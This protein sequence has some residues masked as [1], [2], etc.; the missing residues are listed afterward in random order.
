MNSDL[1]TCKQKLY[2]LIY[3]H[4]LFALGYFSNSLDHDPPIYGQVCTI[5]PNFLLVEMGSCCLPGVA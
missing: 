3:T 2:H 5:V 1:C 4:S